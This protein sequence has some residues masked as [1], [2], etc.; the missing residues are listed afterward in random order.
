MKIFDKKKHF[1]NIIRNTFL[2]SYKRN[3]ELYLENLKKDFKV[4]TVR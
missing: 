2:P 4:N 3:A 1:V